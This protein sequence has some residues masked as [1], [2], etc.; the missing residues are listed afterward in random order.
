MTSTNPKEIL[1]LHGITYIND[2]SDERS[3]ER[4]DSLF[5]Y[6]QTSDINNVPQYAQ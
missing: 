2:E 4:V 1:D 3:Q 6:M 5:R